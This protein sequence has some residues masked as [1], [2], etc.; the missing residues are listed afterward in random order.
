MYIM[1][2]YIITYIHVHIELKSQMH[3]QV[4]KSKVEQGINRRKTELFIKKL[5]V[6]IIHINL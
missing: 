2:M 1:Y 6:I 5:W 3:E 4:W